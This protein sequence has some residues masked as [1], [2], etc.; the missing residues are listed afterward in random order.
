L[1]LMPTL[2]LGAPAQAQCLSGGG[3]GFIQV[4]TI[5]EA[6]IYVANDDCTQNYSYEI[7]SFSLTLQGFTAG[8][9]A[10][11]APG[12]GDSGVHTNNPMTT[13]APQNMD[14]VVGFEGPYT[15][16]T[17]SLRD[18]GT[19]DYLFEGLM[20][21]GYNV[22]PMTSDVMGF[23]ADN[24][25]P[26][27]SPSVTGGANHHV[28]DTIT[29]K[30]NASDPDGG[31][32]TY[33]WSITTRP[34]GSPGSISNATSSTATIALNNK[35]NIG[36]WEIQLRVADNEGEQKT[37]T[38]SFDVL[39]RPP[40]IS[41]AGATTIDALTDIELTGNPAQD[42]DGETLTWAWEITAA[43]P[44]SSHQ[45][46]SISTDR[47]IT[48]P[49]GPED[50]GTF[51]FR[52]TA[53]DEHNAT[54]TALV[55]VTVNAIPP[56]IDLVGATEI[57]VFDTIDLQTTILDDAYGDP[58][59][60]FE[61]ELL[62]VP[63]G[64][65]IALGVVETTAHLTLATGEADA[66]T[67][68]FRLTVT[69]QVG[70]TAEEEVSVLVDALP[71]V[72]I[73]G[74]DQTGNLTLDLDLD[75]STSSDPDSPTTPPDYGH[76]H[77]GPV[78]ISP[79]IVRYSWSVLEVPPEH[80]GAYFPGP[81]A[82]V[83]GANGSSANLH[84]DA[85]DLRAGG[86]L[87]Q[88]EI[89]DGEGNIDSTTHWVTVIEEG[90]PPIVLLSQPSYYLL[91]NDG[92]TT[93]PIGISGANSFDLDNLLDDPLSAGLGITN[94][95]WSWSSVPGTCPFP[96]SPPSGPSA[97]V[98]LM[99]SGGVP[100]PG[101][102]QGVYVP[103]LT[104]T[105]DDTPTPRFNSAS[106]L[107]MIGN[108]AGALCIDHPTTAGPEYVRLS[109]KTDVLIYYH[110][111]SVLY[112][113][114]AYAAGLRLQ[115]VISNLL[116]PG[117]PTYDRAFDVDLL[118]SEKGGPLVV[119]W[120]GYDNNGNR[121]QSGLYDVTLQ[122]MDASGALTGDFATQ[123]AAIHIQRLDIEVNP[124]AD[125]FLNLN[126]VAD[127]TDSLH[128]PYTVTGNA[129]GETGYD[130]LDFRIYEEST[131]AL[132]FTDSDIGPFS[133]VLEWTGEIGPGLL[134]DPGR[135]EIEIEMFDN[136]ASLGT[137]GRHSFDAYRV[138]ADL[139]GVADADEETPGGHIKVGETISL[140]VSVEGNLPVLTGTVTIT[141]QNE[142]GT[143]RA[144][145]GA[146]SIAI[147]AGADFDAAGFAAPFAF[148]LEGLKRGTSDATRIS[149]TFTPDGGGTS[150]KVAEDRV[151][152]AVIAG[153]ARVAASD[154]DTQA[155]D[156]VFLRGA[157]TPVAVTA[158]N[159]SELRLQMQP[160][161]VKVGPKIDGTTVELSLVEGSAANIELY[162]DGG[163]VA[164]L[165]LP[166]TWS[167]ADFAGGALDL[168]LLAYGKAFGTAKLKL[169]W[170]DGATVLAS[171]ELRFRITHE[172]GLVG[173]VVAEFPFL[174]PLAARNTGAAVNVGL[175]MTRHAELRDR[176]VAIYVVQHKTPAQWAADPTLAD[177]T[178][179]PDI[180]TLTNASISA[181]TTAVWAA[182]AAGKYDVV[183]DMGNA[184]ANV[185]DFTADNRMDPGDLLD[186]LAGQ[187]SLSVYGAF[188][189]PGP[190]ATVTTDYGMV[191][192]ITT[193]HMPDGFD[194]LSAAGGYD[195]R[196][197]G[198]VV[199][200]D[201]MPAAAPIIIM[202][203]GN[204]TPRSVEPVGLGA[205]VVVDADLTNDENFRG[206]T[207]LQ[208][209]LASHGYVTISVD[210][211]EV[212]G[213]AA[214]VAPDIVGT[215]GIQLRGWLV[216]K[217]L[218]LAL[219]DAA[220]AGGALAGRIDTA[221]IYFIGHSRG[222]E[223]VLQAYD[224]LLSAA[225]R[226]AGEVLAAAV[227]G[228]TV[229]GI[230][231]M[232]P[233]T[234]SLN[235]GN[236]PAQNVP[237]LLLYGTADGDVSGAFPAVAPFRHYDSGT[238]DRFAVV[239][240]GANHNFWNDS[241]TASDATHGMTFG[242]PGDWTNLVPVLKAPAVGAGLI[243]RPQ[244]Q[245]LAIAYI[246]AFLRL[247]EGGDPGA[248]AYLTTPATRLRPLGVDAA[249]N[250]HGQNNA[251]P[252][253][254][255][256]VFD[257]YET[258]PLTTVASSSE[259]V[260]LTGLANAG[261]GLLLDTNLAAVNQ[262]QDRFFQQTRGVVFEWTAASSYDEPA[263]AAGRDM[264]GARVITLRIAQQARHPIT[265]A[266]GGNLTFSLELEDAAGNS[267]EMSSAI[268][269]QIPGIYPS[270]VDGDDTTKSVFTTLRFPVHGFEADGTTIDLGDI[271]HV[272]LRFANGAFSGQGRIAID[273]I[274]LER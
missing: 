263:P 24:S 245:A 224:Q 39:N 247:V 6:W 152:V 41:V 175:D 221:R 193:A 273:D 213:S 233:T 251:G 133:G 89:E 113:L 87:F 124:G 258:N 120:S 216:L 154:P 199:R 16:R 68:R 86:W 257:D 44:A 116:T 185:V 211:D 122:L 43:P 246:G 170:R 59:A 65:G 222:G 209:W 227:T 69:D 112:D 22:Y 130:Q 206:H 96:P 272:R 146:S 42:A 226:P 241:W 63:V 132:M 254:T 207:W 238:A 162:L 186:Q 187:P 201:P 195:F 12:S 183:V 155:T 234:Q 242:A 83:F 151:A 197:R 141:A 149:V 30:A 111:N 11:I 188:G 110:L 78:S 100:I 88:L 172:P 91:T 95:A 232:A 142:P 240:E 70:E 99:F 71:T 77:D 171:E 67:W 198:R 256:V 8:R 62:Q 85:H 52:V 137:S 157:A 103:T 212:H 119:H 204:H 168:D 210:L 118:P 127:G 243:T 261:E 36:H 253:V 239:C 56:E 194:G 18:I 135:Y 47:T 60:A 121:P 108:C 94:Y 55:T 66:G 49:T 191:A 54:D 33:N 32:L 64:A 51:T 200:P 139:A 134:L 255:K 165:T 145:D 196:L 17:L 190:L 73:L 27:A 166:K 270:E 148:T 160:V 230:V 189:A 80:Y 109:D 115:L 176:R 259:T 244:Q 218:E 81:V 219:T 28:G 178:G 7:Y 31:S 269:G 192:P 72:A 38:T 147:D 90:M 19:Y 267:R 14:G 13:H 21:D 156:G 105:D 237:F 3:P 61:W 184:P 125:A 15:F 266:L 205:T 235:A 252:A 167:D 101:I 26:T 138:N 260:V 50:I 268:L 97:S 117:L 23:Y 40:D 53:T 136:G 46:S 34:A 1:A 84:L 264:R 76:L 231:S 92:F 45:P 144:D 217:N 164:P 20:D 82:D 208:T 180:V 79:G 37:F 5:Y 93:G 58:M 153:E 57:D 29:L 265:A 220:F 236:L 74:P 2:M 102:C 131:N 250:L 174:L 123:S 25:P 128:I 126:G 10:T 214:F 181:N 182:A 98:F 161:G 202:A 274:G 179:G 225:H 106:G 169:E 229:R 223:A 262:P 129:P 107:V 203:H 163:P 114:P 104:V 4:K 215:T 9:T 158:A 48:I 177:V 228:G 249:L 159:F 35:L 143:L 271:R 150:A 173:E 75:G 248:R 140:T